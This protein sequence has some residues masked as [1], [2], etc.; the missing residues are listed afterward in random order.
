[1]DMGGLLYEQNLEL[2]R[3]FFRKRYLPFRAIHCLAISCTSFKMTFSASNT[4]SGSIVEEQYLF[5]S[6]PEI[7]E[8]LN[9]EK[10]LRNDVIV[11]LNI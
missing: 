7:S 5:I 3:S 9:D 1:M 6:L 8:K 4:I 2:L 11:S 10:K